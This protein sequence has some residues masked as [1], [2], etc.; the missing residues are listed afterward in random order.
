MP[1]D[2]P[3]HR[4]RH[5][6]RLRGR[7]EG[8]ARCRRRPSATI[9]DVAHDVP[10]A[11][12][13]ERAAGARALLAALPARDRAPRGRGS[14]AWAARARALAVE[15]DGRLLVGPDN[16]VL[17]PALLPRAR[18][19]SRCRVPPRAAPTFHGRDVFA[20]AA[21]QLALGR[22]LDALGRRWTIR[23]SAARRRRGAA[24]TARRGEVI[25]VD[26]FGNAIT[27]LARA[28]AAGQIEVDGRALPM[29]RTYADAAR[30]RADGARSGSNGLVEIA[31]RDGQRGGRSSGLQRGAPWHCCRFAERSARAASTRPERCGPT[32]VAV[33]GVPGPRS[34]V[35]DAAAIRP[36]PCVGDRRRP[37]PGAAPRRARRR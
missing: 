11:R 23:W 18:A 17:S 32:R 6:R 8:R 27:N 10:A 16:G 1:I 25:A 35:D 24:P 31:V 15:S 14:R 4:L 5:R 36:S 12:R 19:W 26:R 22:S 29:R 3:A 33:D 37:C 34:P 20:P 9:V 28:C 7:D 30:G 2:H 13:R 21:A